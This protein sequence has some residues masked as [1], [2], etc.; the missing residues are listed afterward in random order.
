MTTARGLLE[1]GLAKVALLDID[2][3]EGDAAVA[4]LTESFPDKKDS[5]IFRVLDVTNPDQISTVTAEVSQLFG[6]IDILTTFAGVVNSTRIVDYTPENF[7]K[8]LDVNT[9]GTF[10]TAQAVVKYA[11]FPQK[12]CYHPDSFS[13]I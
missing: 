9:T 2:K 5:I 13:G 7:R 11:H 1:H 8:I 6:G 10:L 3:A 4:G 12:L